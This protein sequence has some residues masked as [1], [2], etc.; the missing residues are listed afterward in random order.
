MGHLTIVNN[1]KEEMINCHGVSVRTDNNRLLAV[2]KKEKI[3]LSNPKQCIGADVVAT[4]AS[5]TTFV[6]DI[7][8]VERT[9]TCI[10]FIASTYRKV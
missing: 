10:K 9:S 8:R 7:N 4:T 5:D 1:G 6:G 2:A 3:D